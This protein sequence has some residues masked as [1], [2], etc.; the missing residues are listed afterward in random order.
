VLKK[1]GLIALHVC[2]GVSILIYYKKLFG[3]KRLFSES[4]KISQER[5]KLMLKIMRENPQCLI[6]EKEDI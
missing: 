6:F 3:S 2:L 1:Q 4:M 5:K